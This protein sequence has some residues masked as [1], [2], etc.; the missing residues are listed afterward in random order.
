MSNSIIVQ[1][2]WTPDDF[3]ELADRAA[4]HETIPAEVDE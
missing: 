4:Q 1:P 3:V 2:I